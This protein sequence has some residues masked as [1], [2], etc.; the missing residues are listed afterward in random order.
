MVLERWAIAGP[1]AVS[2]R[3]KATALAVGKRLG[4]DEVHGEPAG[5]LKMVERMQSEGR[6]VAM[7]GDIAK[8]RPDCR[9]WY[10]AKGCRLR[11]QLDV[12]G[13]LP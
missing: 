13:T 11:L 4:I 12:Y 7:A 2:D 3:I 9:T 6:V 1:L 5:K 8:W 10:R